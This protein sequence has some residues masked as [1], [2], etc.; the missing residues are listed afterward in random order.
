ML[1][2]AGVFAFKCFLAPS[3]VDEFP[4]VGEHDLRAAIPAVAALGTPLMV[5]AELPGYLAAPGAGAASAG[6]R[7]YGS[8]LA[9]RPDAAETEGVVLAARVAEESGARV[10]IVHVSSARTLGVLRDAR[11]RGVAITADAPY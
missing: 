5:H 3:G 8:Y 1:Y 4:P 7:R 10:H 6:G 11:E 9:S 2:D